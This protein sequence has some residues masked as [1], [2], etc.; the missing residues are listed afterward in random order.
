M[1]LLKNIKF[2]HMVCT[3]DISSNHWFTELP[4]RN[5]PH[6]FL[7]QKLSIHLDDQVIKSN[8]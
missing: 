8:P 6:E 3:T 5:M 1:A 2:T 7:T 4:L